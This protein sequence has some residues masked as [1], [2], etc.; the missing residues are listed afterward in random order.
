M[1]TFQ[2]VLITNPWLQQK[3]VHVSIEV[4]KPKQMDAT[5]RTHVRI[6]ERLDTSAK[7]RECRAAA[8]DFV[9]LRRRM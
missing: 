6:S 8:S 3:K 7:Q 5:A 4:Q 9:L 2:M 1:T